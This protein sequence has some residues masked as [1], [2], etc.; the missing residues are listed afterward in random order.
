MEEIRL[1]NLKRQFEAIKEDVFTAL[2]QIATRQEFTLGPW[3]EK[4]EKEFADYIGTTHAVGVNSGTDALFFSLQALGIGEGDEVITV[5][6]S[7]IATALAVIYCRAKPVFVDI[8]PLTYNMDVENIKEKINNKTKAII[9]VHLYGRPC[10]LDPI[11]D[12][13]QDHELF[14]IEDAC[15]AHGALYKGKKVGSF[16]DTGCFSFY[17][18]KNLG[19]YGDGGMVTSNVRKIFDH[20][21]SVRNY[22]RKEKNLMGGI[23]YNSRLDAIQAAVLSIKLKRLDE[24]NAKRAELS[25][26]YHDNLSDLDEYLYLPTLTPIPN[27]KDDNAESGTTHVWHLYEIQ[28]NPKYNPDDLNRFLD[29][30]GIHAE[31]HYPIPIH[32]Q[33]S[34]RFLGYRKGDFPVTEQLAERCIDLPLCPYTTFDEARYVVDKLEEFFL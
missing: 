30:N 8:D 13:A 14:V 11:M 2:N 20:V 4:F 34:M 10:N 22:G 19:A 16:G 31:R 5:P 17:P 21:S 32:L 3:V 15:Q 27:L 23:G 6:N 18:G 1:Y 26:F 28:V 7:Y 24:W 9:P 25:R 33:P 12:I 29:K